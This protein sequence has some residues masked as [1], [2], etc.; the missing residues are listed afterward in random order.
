MAL[1]N[2]G[3]GKYHDE[4]G[5]LWSALVPKS[6]QS[7]TIQGEAVRAIG[8]LGSEYYRNGNMNWTEDFLT[9]AE[10]LRTSISDDSVFSGDLL[11]QINQDMD[12]II[13]N[14]RTGECPYKDD[15]DEYDRITDRVVEF[16]RHY[17]DPR[18]VDTKLPF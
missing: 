11:V 1:Y 2:D 12:Q 6:G 4:Y 7:R 16:C 3:K 5:K 10:W 15:E 14:G 18:V 8:R 13:R 17:S 9:L